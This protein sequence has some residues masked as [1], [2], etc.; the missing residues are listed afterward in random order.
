M[1]YTP[2]AWANGVL[3]AI[4]ATNLNK[5][6]T[7]IED[8]H[9]TA[10]AAQTRDDARKKL[11][12]SDTFT[13]YV[14]SGLLPPTS[15]DLTT[16]TPSGV[17]YVLGTRVEPAAVTRTYAA[18]SDT[19]ADLSTS[20]VYTYTAVPNGGAEPAVAADS[21]RV[22][23]VVTS[24][25]AITSVTAILTRYPTSNRL[26]VARQA[27]TPDNG[28]H[29]TG[30]DAALNTG[31]LKLY[32][33]SFSSGA[34]SLKN[35]AADAITAFL[36][37]PGGIPTS[38]DTA[39]HMYHEASNTTGP[40]FFG[41]S[42]THGYVNGDGSKGIMLV[43]TVS[44]DATKRILDMRFQIHQTAN[45]GG[46]GEREVFRI[47]GDTADLRI[48]GADVTGSPN[49]QNIKLKFG[50]TIQMSRGDNDRLDMG[51]GDKLRFQGTGGGAEFYS[52]N[53]GVDNPCHVEFFHNSASPAVGDQLGFVRFH[54]NDSLGNKTTYADIFGAIASPTDASE[55]ARIDF[56]AMNAGTLNT[57]LSLVPFATN[58]G[59]L[60]IGTG[61]INWSTVVGGAVDTNLYRGAA[62]RL[63]TDDMFRVGNTGTP[64]A[65][66]ADRGYFT[67]VEGG[68]GVADKLYLC[69]KN[70]SDAYVWH[71]IV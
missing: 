54:G 59:I 50:D 65:A 12:H 4:N 13:D 31:D 47:M 37:E 63:A 14:V 60:N 44:T 42:A 39:M 9:T 68:A 27:A 64:T 1:P 7:G 2:T 33:Q 70:A 45:G 62:D 69:I 41:L 67:R 19:Y 57:M 18:S 36:V 38:G 56:R 11:T 6:E 26:H 15:L 51:S 30:T 17:A 71:Q 58:G 35:T 48:C 61:R 28:L 20:G 53:A 22:F 23:K 40:R 46:Y 29:F 49:P 43:E 32:V 10:D 24:L 16:T 21:V 3:P 8:A 25:T 34:L 55:S 5:M 52:E 66:A